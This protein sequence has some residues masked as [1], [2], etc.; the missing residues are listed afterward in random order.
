MTLPGDE[1]SKRTIAA[2]ALAIIA[3]TVLTIEGTYFILK[4][5]VLDNPDDP[6]A[7]AGGQS[8]ADDTMKAKGK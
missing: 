6:R 2:I 7:K 8:P 1:L 4:T 3:A 5:Y